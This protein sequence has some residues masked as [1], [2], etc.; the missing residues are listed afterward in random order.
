MAANVC[1]YDG[2]GI[3]AQM[4]DDRN[5]LR[6]QSKLSTVTKLN[7]EAKLVTTPNP[8]AGINTLLVAVGLMSTINS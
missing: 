7:K 8:Q 4:N 2:L 1:V 5:D 6:D 3:G